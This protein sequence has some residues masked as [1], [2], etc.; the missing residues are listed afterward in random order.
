MLLLLG[1]L[2]YGGTHAPLGRILHAQA[3]PLP[4][5]ARQI[6][7]IFFKNG[8]FLISFALAQNAASF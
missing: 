3:R 6:K 7:L 1:W 4:L 2:I 8:F 5:P